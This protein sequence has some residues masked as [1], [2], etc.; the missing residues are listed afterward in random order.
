M[1]IVLISVEGLL[2][3]HLDILF[4]YYFLMLID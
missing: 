1:L 2:Y 4:V 3:Q